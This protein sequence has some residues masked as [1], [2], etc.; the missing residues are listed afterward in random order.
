MLVGAFWEIR[1]RCDGWEQQ[2]RVKIP[3]IDT[4]DVEDV[5]VVDTRP[6]CVVV[7]MFESVSCHDPDISRV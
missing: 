6:P 2:T 5:G 7:Y 1:V 4:F 3:L